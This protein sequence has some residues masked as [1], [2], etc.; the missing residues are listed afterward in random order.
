MTNTTNETEATKA[1]RTAITTAILTAIEVDSDDVRTVLRSLADEIDPEGVVTRNEGGR[2]ITKAT[3]Y[4]LCFSGLYGRNR[5]PKFTSVAV[6]RVPSG[7]EVDATASEMA[8]EALAKIRAKRGTWVLTK[9]E[10]E[11]D[12]PM[13]RFSID[14]TIELAK[15]QVG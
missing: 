1:L 6:T 14:D 13:T 5:T 7:V 4:T 2:M 10:V 12:G 8:A 3:D 11:I 15:G 9:Y